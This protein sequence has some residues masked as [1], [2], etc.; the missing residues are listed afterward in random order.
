[1]IRYILGDSP[2]A[3]ASQAR[4]L[5]DPSP[6]ARWAKGH[7]HKGVGQIG[8]GAVTVRQPRIA[9]CFATCALAAGDTALAQ[10]FACI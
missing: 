10:P 4:G 3:K 8:D 2:T 7:G 5:T 1:M 6:S 9:H